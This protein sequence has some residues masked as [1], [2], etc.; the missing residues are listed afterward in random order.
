MRLELNDEGN[1]T[2]SCSHISTVVSGSGR[3]VTAAGG[4]G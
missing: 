4:W 2:A 3:V 1:G